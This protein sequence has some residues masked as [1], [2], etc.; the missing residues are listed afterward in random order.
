MP[1]NPFTTKTHRIQHGPMEQRRVDKY[2]LMETLRSRMMSDRSPYDALFADIQA[3]L[4]PHMVIQDMYLAG[5]PD[6][7]RDLFIT[8]QHLLSFD[9]LDAGL[10]EGIIPSAQTWMRYGL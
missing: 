3:V 9:D 1:N 10:Q 5:F 4:D 8:S 6:F 7:V 2:I